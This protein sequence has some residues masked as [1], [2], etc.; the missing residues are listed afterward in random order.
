MLKN[1]SPYVS[2]YLTR[3]SLVSYLNN[4]CGVS[5]FLYAYTIAKHVNTFIIIFFIC[6]SFQIIFLPADNI[7]LLMQPLNMHGCSRVVW[8]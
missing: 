4:V 5:K 1:D 7:S 2:K 8:E 3:V 6:I